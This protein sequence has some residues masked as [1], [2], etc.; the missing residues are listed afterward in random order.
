MN[1]TGIPATVDELIVN[2]TIFGACNH[3]DWTE[4]C[5]KFEQHF[6]VCTQCGEE[7]PYFNGG[8]LDETPSASPSL[9]LQS[10]VRKYSEDDVLASLV[11]RTIE[12]A[13][14]NTLIHHNGDT[15]ACTFSRR[16]V[17]FASKSLPTRAAA[18][19]EAASKLG[20]SGSFSQNAHA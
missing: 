19:C 3:R 7:F 10:A 1:P 17:Q 20:A 6:L 11:V 14:W 16:G 15:Y 9:F 5:D 12:A 13:G 18:I 4:F 8:W 2:E